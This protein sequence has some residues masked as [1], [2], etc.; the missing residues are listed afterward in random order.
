MLGF[1]CWIQT[2]DFEVVMVKCEEIVAPSALVNLD[3][4][5]ALILQLVF[6][7]DLVAW[8]KQL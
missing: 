6:R 5:V 4:A 1:D 8:A 3:H 7:D 2:N